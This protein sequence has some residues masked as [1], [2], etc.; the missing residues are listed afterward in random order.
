MPTVKGDGTDHSYIRVQIIFLWFSVAV[1]PYVISM[2][3]L[4]II[5]PLIPP[6]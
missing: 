4:Q 1:A 6:K 3:L 2:Y 5:R